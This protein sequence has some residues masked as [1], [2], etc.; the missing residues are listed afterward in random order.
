MLE[1]NYSAPVLSIQ[2]MLGHAS[3]N[4]KLYIKF[5]RIK[6]DL[7]ISVVFRA[8]G[9]LTDKEI[10]YYIIDN[11][12]SE[13]DNIIIKILHGSLFKKTQNITSWL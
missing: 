1:K 9:C 3:N 6:K 2:K 10:L 8:L 12:G 5:P 13:I 11:D 7:P 4:C